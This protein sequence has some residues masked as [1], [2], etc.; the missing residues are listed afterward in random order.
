MAQPRYISPLELSVLA[1]PATVRPEE[2]GPARTSLVALVRG[3]GSPASSGVL[4]ISGSAF[5]EHEVRIEIVQGGEINAATFKAWTDGATYGDETLITGKPQPLL[6][7]AP[8]PLEL[9]T[10]ADTGL[11]LLFTGGGSAPS[12]RAGDRWTFTTR[13]IAAVL[14]AIIAAS[15]AARNL[16]SGPEDTGGGRYTGDISFDDADMKRR[17][18]VLARLQLAESRGLDPQSDA[19]KLY[20]DSAEKAE[21]ALIEVAAKLRHPRVTES[22]PE[23]L[24]PSVLLG[25]DRGGISAAHRARY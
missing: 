9:T 23:T 8:D 11:R 21:K 6:S 17:V 22:G 14:A 12:F 7:T 15:T 13:P 24:G 4:S 2:L 16:V 19:G 10:G 25:A 5:D 18:A 1:W 20:I 3:A